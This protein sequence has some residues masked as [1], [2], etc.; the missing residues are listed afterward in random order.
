MSSWYEEFKDEGPF[1]EDTEALVKY[2]RRV[3]LEERDL[4][5]AVSVVKWVGWLIGQ[6]EHD[7]EGDGDDGQNEDAWRRALTVVQDG[8]QSAIKERGLG[9][10]DF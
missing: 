6:S 7:R 8:V 4:D 1:A 10:V 2:L 3:V 9:M 5:K